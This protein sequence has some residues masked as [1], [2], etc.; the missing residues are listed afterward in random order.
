MYSKDNKFAI[1][2]IL[3]GNK[4]GEYFLFEKINNEWK[5]NKK[6]NWWKKMEAA[7]PQMF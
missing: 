4:S 2:G 5:I 6:L 3:Y 1:L 7:T